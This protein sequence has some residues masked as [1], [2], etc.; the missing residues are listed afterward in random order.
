MSVKI[1]KEDVEGCNTEIFGDWVN[2]DLKLNTIPFKYCIIENFLNEEMYEKICDKFPENPNDEFWKYFNPIEVKYVLDKFEF[3]NDEIKNL[4]FAL[5]CD[6]LIKKFETLFDLED[7][8]YDPYL[9]GAGIH[10]HPTNGRLS[11][12]L[13]YEK[14][15]LM[16]KQ[17]RL[18]IIY[19]VNKEWD[20][21]WNGDTQLWDK[22][23]KNCVIKSYPQK[24]KAI[25][26]ETTE[27]SWHGVPDK[28]NCPKHIYRKSIAYYYI[29]P[30][31]NNSNKNK[32][33][34]NDDGYRTKA[35]FIKRP[36]DPS[37]ERMEK[38]Y[39]IRPHRRITEKDMKEIWPE[40]N[41]NF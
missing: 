25:I 35:V 12:H 2:K 31:I 4:F 30:L 38:L 27:D 6:K 32:Q 13:D 29:S 19:Y 18:N 16:N 40:W 15:P 9:H 21:E 7:L 5:S 39:K 1:S 23:M 8:E 11:M 28:I 26:F 20:E 10:M 33:G 34:V 41:L 36:Q 22:N 37:D 3:I 17:R 24:N 14:H